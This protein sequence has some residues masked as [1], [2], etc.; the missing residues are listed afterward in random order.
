[1][2]QP[3]EVNVHYELMQFGKKMSTVCIISILSVIFSEILEIINIIVLFSALKNMERIYGAIPDISL[4]K[5]KSNIRTAIR[6]QILGFIT[7]IGVVI[8]I[9]IF[10]TIA[11]SNGSGN[12]N[13]KDLSFIINISFSIAILACI[14]IVLASVFMMSGWSDLNTF[15]INHGDVFEGVLRDDVQKGSKYLRRAYL[16]EILTY[17][18]MIIILVLFINFIP[19]IILLDS[20]S[21]ISPEIFIPL[22]IVVAVPGTGL[23]ITWL[24][25]F[26]FKILGYYKLASLRYIKAQS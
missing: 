20:E 1:M 4:K 26:T 15:F 5:F 2:S 3:P 12:I 16:L 14:V 17:I 23:I 24:T 22:M 7:L 9:S 21:E 18:M 8:A 25:S 19:E 10:M 6:I 11:F 13:I